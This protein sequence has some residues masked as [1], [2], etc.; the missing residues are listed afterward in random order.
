MK[1][2][3]NLQEGGG[4]WRLPTE[5]EL[6]KMAYYVYKDANCGVDKSNGQQRYGVKAPACKVEIVTKSNMWKFSRDVN[7][8][9]FEIWS[10]HAKS[11]TATNVGYFLNTN[12]YIGG[13]P[14]DQYPKL[15]LCV[16]QK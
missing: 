5:K 3:Q 7:A 13:P 2:C 11:S 1:Y 10:N 4:G 8:S 9:E 15:A 16:R 6:S 14:R 12:H